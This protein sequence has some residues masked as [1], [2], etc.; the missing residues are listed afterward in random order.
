MLQRNRTHTADP[1]ETF[2]TDRFRAVKIGEGN[3][4]AA[5]RRPE[6]LFLIALLLLA[7]TSSIYDV[8][9]HR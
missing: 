9:C 3:A 4:G 5:A 8:R 7:A 6:K 1:K 2:V